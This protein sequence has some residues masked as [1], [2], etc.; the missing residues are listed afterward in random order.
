MPI[1]RIAEVRTAPSTARYCASTSCRV[2][3]SDRSLGPRR[4]CHL[5]PRTCRPAK[6]FAADLGLKID[7]ASGPDNAA[8]RGVRHPG[9]FAASAAGVGAHCNGACPGRAGRCSRCRLQGGPQG[10]RGHRHQ[11]GRRAVRHDSGRR[12][13]VR[14]RPGPDQVPRGRSWLCAAGEVAEGDPEARLVTVR[15]A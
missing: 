15:A 7:R 6:R 2:V 1:H 9:A 4:H 12:H 13:A 8:A 11:T 10:Q 5:M 14:A 3:P